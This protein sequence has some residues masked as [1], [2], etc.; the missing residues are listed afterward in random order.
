MSK[1]ILVFFLLSILFFSNC[2][3]KENA[4]PNPTIE[5]LSLEPSSIQEFNDEVIVHIKYTD[6][7]GDLGEFDP[8]TYTLEVKDSRLQNPDLYHVAPLVYQGIEGEVQ[9]EIKLVINNLFRIGN[10]A[11]ETA[12]LTI[13]F[14]DKSGNWSNEAISPPFII[15]E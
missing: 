7:N 14:Q 11:T 9:G 8:D 1:L 12:T 6:P 2:K 15:K 4:P 10:G 13:R 5:I 3:K